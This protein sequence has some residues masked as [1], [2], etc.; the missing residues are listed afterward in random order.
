M[1][2][3]KVR[4]RGHTVDGVLNNSLL[5]HTAMP[6]ADSKDTSL[7]PQIRGN[8]YELTKS[9]TPDNPPIRRHQYMDFIFVSAGTVR[10]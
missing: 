5:L 4:Q 7:Q 1:S 8:G 6:S 10:L 9:E 2:A 3:C